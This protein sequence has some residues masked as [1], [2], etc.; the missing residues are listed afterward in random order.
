[1][2]LFA[3]LP[4]KLEEVEALYC[5]ASNSYAWL[6]KTKDDRIVS[7]CSDDIKNEKGEP[8]K[9]SFRDTKQ[10]EELKSFEVAINRNNFYDLKN[11][12]IDSGHMK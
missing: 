12:W 3:R 11:I 5:G 4:N 6:L 9:A 1:M 8:F 7:V 10:K 2:K